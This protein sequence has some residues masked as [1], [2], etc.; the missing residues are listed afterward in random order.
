MPPPE[1]VAL[2]RYR[3][4]RRLIEAVAKQARKSWRALS[5]KDLDGSWS[6]LSPSLL[7]AL[8]GAQLAAANGA[9]D[10]LDAVLTAQNIDPEADGA[11][12][13][14]QLAGIASDGR[15]LG[16]LLDQPIIAAKI[17]IGG[18]ATTAEAMATG[19][20]SLDMIVRTQVADA[21]RVADQVAL[22]S[23]RHANGY[24][25]MVVGKTCSRC[26]ILAGKW[27]AYNTG[28]QRHP[29]CDCVHIPSSETVGADMAVSPRKTFDAMSTAEQDKVF[30]KAGAEA[31]RLGAD[32]AQVVNVRRGAAGLTPAGARITADEARMLRGGRDLG[33]LQSTTVFGQQVFTTT[34]G[35]TTRGVAGRR[36][37]ARETGVKTKGQRYRN[38]RTPRLMPE[39]ILAAARNREDAIRLLKRFGYIL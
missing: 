29:N 2:K 14:R 38:S 12:A 24:V 22:T 5:T 33:R 30:T 21:G 27:Y 28:F 35:T 36:L 7:L 4:R 32:P 1:T 34:E 23:R 25:R 16:T 13:A 15:E 9:D 31:I 6:M 39:S 11:T 19:Y 3:E 17:A 18:G 26:I 20:A 10:Y 8:S 37:G